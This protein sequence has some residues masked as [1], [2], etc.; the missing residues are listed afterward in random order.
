[1]LTTKLEII[2]LLA[3]LNEARIQILQD[4]K[5]SGGALEIELGNFAYLASQH[6]GIQ[7]LD[8]EHCAAERLTGLE[9][10]EQTQR[11]LE[12]ELHQEGGLE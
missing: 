10:A 1:M 3:L 6:C 4:E 2:K 9:I 12:A 11:L 5:A 8:A 7:H